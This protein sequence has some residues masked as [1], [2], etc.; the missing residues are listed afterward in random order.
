MPIRVDYRDVREV[1]DTAAEIN[2]ISAAIEDASLWIDANL[3]GKCRRQS[4]ATLARVEKYLAAHLLA[5]GIAS[6]DALPLTSSTRADISE[7]YG[8][9]SREF[10]ERRFVM[11]AAAFDPC[12]IVGEHWLGITRA[13]AHVGRG[14]A[15]SR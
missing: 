6:A 1:L 12:G 13:K 14:Y 4:E 15:R 3:L 2:D 10:G 5:N 7:S 9:A 8:Q 11:A